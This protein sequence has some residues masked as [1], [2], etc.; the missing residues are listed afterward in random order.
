MAIDPKKVLED[1]QADMEREEQAVQASAAKAKKGPKTSAEKL[2]DDGLTPEEKKA[3]LAREASLKKS[4]DFVA[5]MKKDKDF[6]DDGSLMLLADSEMQDIK[7]FHSGSMKLDRVLGGGWPIGRIHEI[8]GPESSGKTTIVYHAIGEAQKA[9]MNVMLVDAEHAFDPLWAAMCGVEVDLLALVQPNTGEE[10]LKYAERAIKAGIEMIAVDSVAALVP[11]AEIEGEIGAS[12]VGLQARMMSQAMRKLVPLVSQ[13]GATM[14]FINQIRMKIGVMFGNPE[15]QPGGNALKFAASI[16][17][18]VRRL[19]ATKEKGDEGDGISNPMK[20]KTV[21]NKT[22]SPHRVDTLT[23]VYPKDAAGKLIR[24]GIDAFQEVVD[25]G[26]A[27]G[28]VTKAGSWYNYVDENGEDVRIGQGQ[29]SVLALFQNDKAI[30]EMIRA[31][32]YADAM[33]AP[34]ANENDL[35]I[36]D[37]L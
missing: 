10:G 1:I 31:R 14:L 33:E 19:K 6:K 2:D 16:R 7:R 22:A 27:S 26:I 20:V 29:A 25:F 18:D 3:L 15:T 32:V 28:A 36:D 17:L 21:K 35:K 12:H 30:Y 11:K 9:G 13:K 8:Y 5:A 23:V 24:G 37:G 34:D 4:R